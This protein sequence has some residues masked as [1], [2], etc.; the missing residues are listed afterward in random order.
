MAA[1]TISPLESLRRAWRPRSLG[2][3]A[4]LVRAPACHAGGRGF[5]SRRSRLT[6]SLQRCEIVVG[7][8]YRCDTE[9]ATKTALRSP[10]RKALDEA[11]EAK[12]EEHFRE[13]AAA[14]LNRPNH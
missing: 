12:T 10:T 4:Q 2:G 6:S 14:I 13:Q 8:R 9:N 1:E 3:V 11:A 5:E 7:D